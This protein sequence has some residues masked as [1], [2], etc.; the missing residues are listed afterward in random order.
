MIICYS[1]EKDKTIYLVS[2]MDPQLNLL[3]LVLPC[4]IC[5]EPIQI[6]DHDGESPLKN[7][8]SLKRISALELFQASNGL[9]FKSEQDAASIGRISQCVGAKI[10]SISMEEVGPRV[11]V[12]TITVEDATGLRIL[13]FGTST[14]GATIF[15]VVQE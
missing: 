10:K 4:P 8:W 7:G 13:H 9:G 15:K 14:K 1:C 2:K 3:G 5:R 6:A 12:N 11:I